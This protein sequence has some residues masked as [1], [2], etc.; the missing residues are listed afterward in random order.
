[1]KRFLLSLASRLSLFVLSISFGMVSYL[2]VHKLGVDEKPARHALLEPVPLSLQDEI[3]IDAEAFLLAKTDAPVDFAGDALGVYYI[4]QQNG[5]VVRVAP[6]AGGGTSATPYTSLAHFETDPDLGFSGLALHPDFHVKEKPGYGRFYVI[7]SEKAGA[8]RADFIPEFGG[9]KEHHQDVLYEYTVEDPLLLAFRGKKREL[10]RFSQPGS[11]NNLSGLTFDPSGLLY[12]GVGDGAAAEVG[13]KSP[14]RNASSLANA[15]GKVL[16]IDPVGHDSL[17]GSYGIPQENPFRLVTGALPELWAFG[18][19]AP[20][21]LSFDPFRRSLCI[22]ESGYLG[23]EEINFSQ[24]GGE[25]F[26]WDIGVDAARLSS[27][28]RAQLAEIVTP[29]A[30]SIDLKS[31]IAARTTG[32]VVYRGES[33][34]SLAG[35]TLFA[36]HDGQIMALRSD[37]ESPTGS[38]VSRVDIGRL[39]QEKFRALR[40]NPR[41]ELIVL[42]EDGSVYEMRKSASLGTGGSSHRSLFCLVPVMEGLKG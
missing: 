15:Y 18:L 17:N 5:D 24:T 42:C 41:G 28:M 11:E 4:L 26:G 3:V 19:R 20:H 6:E 35:N 7:T 13:R 32:S 40:T 36:S 22:S 14:S 30:I 10:M 2:V 12:V 37:L 16:R 39:G 21:S 38:K 8:G 29:P 9:G 27:S 23:E 1:M 33:F 25:H 34:P 31:G